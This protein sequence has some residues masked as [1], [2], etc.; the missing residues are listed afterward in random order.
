MPATL[1]AFADN[2]IYLI[3]WANRYVISDDIIYELKY[4]K[5]AF[6][7]SLRYL[8][9]FTTDTFI[10]QCIWLK[11]H[12][13]LLKFVSNN[14]RSF[15]IMYWQFISITFY[16]PCQILEDDVRWKEHWVSSWL[17][18]LHHWDQR[19]CLFDFLSQAYIPCGLETAIICS[20]KHIIWVRIFHQFKLDNL[21][22]CD[23]LDIAKHIECFFKISR[24]NCAFGNITLTVG[25]ISS[26]SNDCN[27]W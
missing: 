5:Q 24:C 17:P 6:L 23:R 21:F 13:K 27:S 11:K 25:K 7:S 19:L 3:L 4:D 10:Y 2:Q 20:N 26:N 9:L 16:S 14:F 12:K 1:L 15:F 18:V 8:S 22:G